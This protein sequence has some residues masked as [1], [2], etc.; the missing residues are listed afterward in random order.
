MIEIVSFIF[1]KTNFKI[2]IIKVFD[3]FFIVKKEYNN[4]KF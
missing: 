4:E 2:I 3:H 1:H